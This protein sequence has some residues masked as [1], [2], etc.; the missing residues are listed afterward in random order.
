MD[1]YSIISIFFIIL[2]A[3]VLFYFGYRI[4]LDFFTL[5]SHFATK[6]ETCREKTPCPLCNSMLYNEENIIS[7][8]YKTSTIR[9]QPCTIHG[10]LHCF[11]ELE[12]GVNRTCPVCHKTVPLKGHLDARIFSRAN[13]KKHVHISGCTE[14]HKKK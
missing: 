11:P 7:R 1:A 5:K 8:V 13:K 12:V 2:V 10:C 3:L 4:F 6:K 14:C 9:D